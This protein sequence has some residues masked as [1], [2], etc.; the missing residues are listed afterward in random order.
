MARNNGAEKAKYDYL[1]FLDSDVLLVED[2]L[3]NVTQSLK[4]SPLDCFG[5]PDQDDENFS[6]V[7]KAVDFTMTSFLTTGGIRG[8][9]N[10]LKIMS[11]EVLI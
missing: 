9:K 8:E 4:K 10:Q 11:P 6:V 2:Y 7:Q 3:E 5:G 1:I